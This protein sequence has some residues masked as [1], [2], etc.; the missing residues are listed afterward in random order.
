MPLLRF[1]V[2]ALLT[3]GVLAGPA[4]AE[5]RDPAT[6]F[7]NEKFGDFSEDL[8]QAR[9]QGKKGVLIMFEMDD[10]PFCTR[11]KKT[12]LNQAAVQDYYRKNFLVFSVDTEGSTM[13]T[14]FSGSEVE[15]RQFASANRARAT[16]VFVFFDLDGKEV[17]RFTGATRNPEEFL[18]LGEYVADGHYRQPG[19]SFSRYRKQARDAGQ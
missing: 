4:L 16:P 3:F 2:T 1:L 9:E 10:C 19:L 15:E 12:V 7:F 18:L 11:M 5:V 6:H 14:D 13:V 17:T 8:A